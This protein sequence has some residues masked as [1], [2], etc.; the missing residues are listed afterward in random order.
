MS[1]TDFTPAG[2][3]IFT[4]RKLQ[5]V[6]DLRDGQSFAVGGLLQ[7]KNT[8][9]QEQVPWLGQVPIVGAL[10]RNSSTQ[11][12]RPSWSSSS[13]RISCGR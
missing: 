7:S 11:K 2:D 8:R 4:S 9:L 13:R 1:V 3:P 5:T 10:F 12:K 6:V